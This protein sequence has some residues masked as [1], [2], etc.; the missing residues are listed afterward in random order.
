MTQNIDRVGIARAFHLKMGEF[1][2]VEK[3]VGHNEYSFKF[4]SDEQKLFWIR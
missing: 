1:N 4:W 3:I 2:D